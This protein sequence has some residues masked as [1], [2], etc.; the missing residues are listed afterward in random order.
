MWGRRWARWLT[1]GGLLLAASAAFALL[2]GQPGIPYLEQP[3]AIGGT[4]YVPP[5]VV[6]NTA[7]PTATPTATATPT[8]TATPTAQVGCGF[9]DFTP[10]VDADDGAIFRLGV[11]ATEWP[12]TS[13]TTARTDQT[14]EVFGKAVFIGLYT[15]NSEIV[16]VWDTSPLGALGRSATGAV[17]D[18]NFTSVSG[19]AARNIVAEW[20]TAGNDG[21]GTGDYILTP[22]GS[23][24]NYATSATPRTGIWSFTLSNPGSINASGKTGLILNVDGGTGVSNPT[25]HTVSLRPGANPPKLRV[26]W[27]ANT[28]TPTRTATATPT[29]TATATAT[30]T[31]TPSPYAPPVVVQNTRTS[32]ATPIFTATVTATVTATP[33]FTATPT[34]T[35]SP[36]IPPVVVENTRTFTATPIF[37]ATITGTATATPTVTA[38]P[39]STATAPPYCRYVMESS[40][41]QRLDLPSL[42]GIPVMDEWVQVFLACEPTPHIPPI[43]VGNTPTVTNTSIATSTATRTPTTTSTPTATA[44]FTQTPSPYAPP[45]VIPNTPT[46]TATQTVTPT[47]TVTRTVTN[48]PVF[49]FT[50][51]ATPSPYIPPVVVRN[52]P[53]NTATFTPTATATSTTTVTA[54]P[55]ATATSTPP[56]PY[57]N[58]AVWYRADSVSGVDGDPVATWPDR[59]G[60]G[61]DASQVNTGNRPV[62]K[63]SIVNGQPVVRFDGTNDYLDLPSFISS[64]TAAEIFIVIKPD[65]YPPSAF[66]SGIWNFGPNSTP[67]SHYSWTTGGIYE[68]FGTATRQDEI[69]PGMSL[70]AWRVYNVTTSSTGW[71]ARLDGTILRSLG[72]NTVAWPTTAR[73]GGVLQTD[74]TSNSYIWFDGDIAEVILFNTSLNGSDRST[75]QSYLCTRYGLAFCANT[76]TPSPYVPPVVVVNS[77]TPTAT[78]TATSTSTRTPT[79]TST[80][81]LT[82]TLT[83]TPSPYIPPVIVVNTRTPTPSP[84]MTATATR[85]STATSTATSTLTFTPT[86]TQTLYIGPVIVP[87]T[88]TP[89]FTPTRTPTVT[90]TSTSTVTVTPTP[91]QTPSPY[92][93]PVVVGNTPTPTFTPT[94]TATV[95]STP[96]AT[97][98]PTATQTPSPYIPP[99]IVVNT[100]T[101]TPTPTVTPTATPT[102]P[103]SSG[104]AA[105]YKADA[106]AG[107]SDGDAVSSWVDSSGNGNTATQATPANQPTWKTSIVNGKP[108]V[109]FMASGADYLNLPNFMSA[110]TAG[111]VFIVLKPTADPNG[112]NTYTGIWNFNNP[113]QYPS[114]YTWSANGFIYEGF[115]TTVR[116]TVGDPSKTTKAW[117]LYNV[118]SA[119]GDYTV[120]Y[121]SDPLYHTA[122]N[123]VYFPTTPRLGGALGTTDHIWVN[124]YL[125]GDI[126]EVLIFNTTLSSGSRSAVE[127]YLCTKYDLEFCRAEVPPI[128]IVNT[129]TPTPATPTP[130]QPAPRGGPLQFW[131]WK[132]PTP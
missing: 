35:P 98:T 10:A 109:R 104:L 89:T 60:N 92:I 108:V 76:P 77:P 38:T 119:A 96:T 110:F 130:T 70:A 22:N 91:T 11:N 127:S 64:F 117:R 115:G 25:S 69:A 97:A 39:T 126:A 43:I 95:T 78:P 41:A 123:T 40:Q 99:V 58:L 44:T 42:P 9:T 57:G 31:P 75:V 23:A 90:V 45:I 55:T 37:T 82:P 20:T 15:I 21:W 80:S 54:T 107:L 79:V 85:T 49:S 93:P 124:L 47:V 13:T 101:V 71:A 66:T 73:I 129:P 120:R 17:L 46:A 94:W 114:H 132:A 33:T 116:K 100:A 18:L 1:V 111:E 27:C 86:P 14:T 102:Y 16:V 125:D 6:L 103:F 81:T 61:R 68:S 30:A 12:P 83:P 56:F 72:S 122:T 7:T 87:N 48:T 128:V 19:D 121:D 32:T 8:N 67:A 59:S 29:T 118:A 52:T 28:A 88:P 106:I 113:T 36:Y 112:T 105:W 2:P 53:T 51:S 74:T 131:L 62:L 26:Y 63:T 50:P 34:N 3:G 4:P 65:T 5:V 24:L 84:T